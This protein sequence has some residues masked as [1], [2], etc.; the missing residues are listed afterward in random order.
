MTQKGKVPTKEEVEALCA[1]PD[2]ELRAL[3]EDVFEPGNAVP[4]VTH[5]SD[6]ELPPPRALEDVAVER[7][8]CDELVDMEVTQPT[9]NKRNP[10][11]SRVTIPRKAAEQLKAFAENHG[12]PLRTYLEAVLHYVISTERRPGSWEG[13][14]PFEFST[15]DTRREDGSFADRWF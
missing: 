7:A 4:G 10:A 2:A 3:K 13:S 11:V 12:V 8:T 6:G 14:Q 9:R 15:Y 1:L 5:S